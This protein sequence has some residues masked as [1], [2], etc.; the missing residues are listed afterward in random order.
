MRIYYKEKKIP[1]LRTNNL[2]LSTQIIKCYKYL[3]QHFFKS[4]ARY[5]SITTYVSKRL[6]LQ[7]E[8]CNH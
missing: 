5:I 8:N 2:L 3:K 4:R 7:S 6:K 1:Y